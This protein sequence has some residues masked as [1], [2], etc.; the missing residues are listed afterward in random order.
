ML[1]ELATVGASRPLISSPCIGQCPSATPMWTEE[2]IVAVLAWIWTRLPRGNDCLPELQT[3]D[4]GRDSRRRKAVR[5]AARYLAA[6]LH[7]QGCTGRYASSAK[8][9]RT[10]D[11][12]WWRRSPCRS[13]DADAI[14][15]LN[16][17]RRQEPNRMTD[18]IRAKSAPSREEHQ[19][20]GSGGF[21]RSVRPVRPGRDRGDGDLTVRGLTEGTLYKA[22][23]RTTWH[24][25]CYPPGHEHI[26]EAVR[27]GVSSRM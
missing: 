4:A 19:V 23:T 27:A 24:P 15:K 20:I 8:G 12:V 3:G 16:S 1:G 26:A 22:A 5:A 11:R 17:L 14:G 9:S 18:A 21:V 7:S 6:L 2:P 25:G 13:R 10:S